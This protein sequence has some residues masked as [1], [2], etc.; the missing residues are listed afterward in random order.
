V[1][2]KRIFGFSQM[3]SC[4]RDF[5][6][7]CP[8]LVFLEIAKNLELKDLYHLTEINKSIRLRCLQLN[9]GLQSLVRNILVKRNLVPPVPSTHQSHSSPTVIPHTFERGDWFL[10][11]TTVGESPSMRNRERI[12]QLTKSLKKRFE[13]I[14]EETG[15]TSDDPRRNHLHVIVDQQLLIRSLNESR[16]PDVF[17]RG[18]AI[19]NKAFEADLKKGRLKGNKLSVA[20]DRVKKMGMER[21]RVC[22]VQDEMRM[23]NVINERMRL[24]LIERKK[25]R[26]PRKD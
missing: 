3:N 4:A 7:T 6:S 13:Q 8:D 17:I 25:Y 22:S 18:M 26:R 10:Y 1:E 14:V 5:L 9:F 20:V 19:L 12:I 2:S 21:G 16:H 15:F 11:G 24:I 23:M